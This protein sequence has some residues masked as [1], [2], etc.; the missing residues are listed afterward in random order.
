MPAPLQSRL[1][2]TMQRE[3]DSQ[4]LQLSPYCL[5]QI[6]ILVGRGVERMRNSNATDNP[7]YVMNA[8][9]NLKSLVKYFADYS[10]NKGSY[11]RLTRSDFDHA[12]RSSPTYWP[13]CSSG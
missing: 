9:R 5:Q 13:Y 1:A 7:G 3:L 12:L 6:E 8:E 10:R 2:V 11:P 4:N